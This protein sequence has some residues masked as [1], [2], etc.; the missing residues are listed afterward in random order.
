MIG[1]EM[2]FDTGYQPSRTGQALLDAV[3]NNATTG[4]LVAV[5][6]TEG[7]VS[8]TNTLLSCQGTEAQ[9]GV[10]RAQ[11]ALKVE[12]SI[13][14]MSEIELEKAEAKL[15]RYKD[16]LHIAELREEFDALKLQRAGL[17]P[18]DEMF[19]AIT[20]KMITINNEIMSL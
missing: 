7:L 5:S 12:K 1:V 10:E 9:I 16:R 19:A 15:V 6:V 14:R 20:G 3:V 4:P 17:S 11:Y 18:D 8:T 13:G 2:A